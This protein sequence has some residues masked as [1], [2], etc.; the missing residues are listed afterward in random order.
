MTNNTTEC[1]NPA[2]WNSQ[3]P[4][5]LPPLP[6]FQPLAKTSTKIKDTSVGTVIERLQ[7]CFDREDIIAEYSI[8]K[9]SSAILNIESSPSVVRVSIHLFQANDSIVVELIKLIGETTLFHRKSRT[10]LLA[11]R[12]RADSK[13][14]G[15]VPV[16]EKRKRLVSLSTSSRPS[17][18]IGSL[19]RSRSK[20]VQ[21]DEEAI[22]G[23][24]K[25]NEL[26]QKDR[27][28]ARI[29]GWKA[30]CAITD[31]MSSTQSLYAARALLCI[32]K[33]EETS[34]VEVQEQVINMILRQSIEVDDEIESKF[35]S[36]IRPLAFCAM[37]NALKTVETHNQLSEVP[38][39]I[40]EVLLAAQRLEKNSTY[41]I[42][43]S[44][45]CLD[46]LS[47][48]FGFSHS[49][50]NE[51]CNQVD[52]V[53]LHMREQQERGND[54]IEAQSSVVRR[55]FHRQQSLIGL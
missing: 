9:P 20:T 32:C 52:L 31:C 26:I 46:I 11:A 50:V 27:I 24:E 15:K 39:T 16:S 51:F 17:S 6:L 3:T 18:I 54:E 36:S 55:A 14:A 40:L 35:A 37:R 33:D 19:K 12:G 13:L 23:M 30:L 29:I 34:I 25:V 28:D 38:E 5:A 2:R 22:L 21:K 1:N 42:S 49:N 48:A 44:N 4:P 10:L 45:E 8:D 7:T 53:S 47:S 43:L 41:E